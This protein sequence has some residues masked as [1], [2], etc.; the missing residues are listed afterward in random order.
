MEFGPTPFFGGDRDPIGV[1]RA[2]HT[3]VRTRD[4]GSA[5]TC[6]AQPTQAQREAARC[7]TIAAESD[8]V[9]LTAHCARIREVSARDGAIVSRMRGT[10]G[11]VVGKR[12]AYGWAGTRAGRV[13]GFSTDG[14]YNASLHGIGPSQRSGSD[15]WL[16]R[17]IRVMSL[18]ARG[19]PNVGHNSYCAQKTRKCAGSEILAQVGCLVA[20]E[21]SRKWEGGLVGELGRRSAG[22]TVERAP[23]WD[24]GEI[25][26][27][28]Q[29]ILI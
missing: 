11:D 22:G 19:L 7:A 26:I 10:M 21:A 15:R 14:P 2:G 4:P 24:A 12:A 16:G 9:S 8:N 13:V 28:H 18:T 17:A 27:S 1:V 23:K 25:T 20:G 3:I 29:H 6:R 5:T